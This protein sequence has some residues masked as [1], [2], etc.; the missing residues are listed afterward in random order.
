MKTKIYSLLVLVIMLAISACEKK[1][2]V[3]AVN[4]EGLTREITDLVPQ[5]ILDTIQSLGMV[6][7]GGNNPPS[8][9]GTFEVEPLILVASTRDDDDLGKQYA[10]YYY[11]FNDQD[12]KELTI[13]ASISSSAGSTG[14]GH[15]AYIVGEGNEFTIFIEVDSESDNGSNKTVEVISGIMSEDGIEGLYM[16]LFMIDDYGDPQNAFIEIGDGRLFYDEDAM[17]ERMIEEKSA[18]LLKASSV[19]VG[20]AIDQSK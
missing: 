12:D 10:D 15:G 6:F 14:E 19:N 2:E 18:T 16:A 7:H 1:D 9:V 3:K 5:E 4:D 11:T 17:S 13:A 20:L 8:L